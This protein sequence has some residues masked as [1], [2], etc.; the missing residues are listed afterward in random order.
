MLLEAY[1][2]SSKDFFFKNLQSIVESI[3]VIF[4]L[5]TILEWPKMTNY[6]T[7]QPIMQ[8]N[9]TLTFFGCAYLFLTYWSARCSILF[10]NLIY[11]G[12]IVNY[13]CYVRLDLFKYMFSACSLEHGI[14]YQVISVIES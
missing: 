1:L 12:F 2:G 9:K 6:K 7:N 14:A 13:K 10:F 5:Y 11:K 4:L 3:F 8:K